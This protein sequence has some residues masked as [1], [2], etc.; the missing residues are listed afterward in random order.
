MGL[1]VATTARPHSC[2]LPQRPR[3]RQHPENLYFHLIS[4]VQQTCAAQCLLRDPLGTP[5]TEGSVRISCCPSPLV[6]ALLPLCPGAHPGAA[7]LCALSSSTRSRFP[8]AL[9][10]GGGDSDCLGALQGWAGLGCVWAV[11]ALGLQL[12]LAAPALGA[13]REE[14]RAQLHTLHAPC[15]TGTGHT[16]HLPVPFWGEARPGHCRVP[17]APRACGSASAAWGVGRALW[18]PAPSARAVPLLFLSLQHWNSNLLLMQR[19]LQ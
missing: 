17:I 19:G 7:T 4:L 5:Q 2:T 9:A 11:P 12:P 3:S 6:T 18:C 13:L 14:G 16:C 10:P 8:V 1:R 15:T